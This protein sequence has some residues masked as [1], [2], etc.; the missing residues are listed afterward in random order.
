MSNWM[1][2]EL[3]QTT[4]MAYRDNSADIPSGIANEMNEAEQ[5][6]KPVIVAVETKPS[7]EGPITFY[8]KGQAQMIKELGN[9]VHTLQ[10][11]PPFTGYAIH[12]Y[13]SWIN[14]KE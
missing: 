13:D 2:R 5:N 1:I 12:E 11:R 8:N 10:N 3:D 9:V 14:L 6:G 7:R 4:L